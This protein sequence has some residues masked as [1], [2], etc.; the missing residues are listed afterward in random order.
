MGG[1]L[2]GPQLQG[3]TVLAGARFDAL[4]LDFSVAIV[5]R[6][7]T[8]FGSLGRA[9]LFVATA[10]ACGP[11]DPS[12][13]RPGRPV[14]INALATSLGRPFETTRRN[15]NALVDAGLI[16]RAPG[17]LSIPTT[18]TP[19]PVAAAFV[20]FSHDLM[21]RLVEDIRATNLP[22][23]AQ[24][25]TSTYDHRVGTGIALDLLL[26]C[27]ECQGERERNLTRLALLG[28]VEWA[29]KRFGAGLGSGRGDDAPVKASAVA[30][31]TGLPYATVSRNL[32]QLV[33]DGELQRR[34]DGLLIHPARRDD[35]LAVDARVPLA[36]R[37][38]QLL[39]RLA[40][41]GFPMQQPAL[42]YLDRR[43]VPAT[44]G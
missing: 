7:V 14:S 22:L 24:Q 4:L 1:D 17:G 34:P 31:I 32:D 42:A 35:P 8:A 36:N 5:P 25:T 38:R 6:A 23:P 26:A 41:T 33:R 37:A 9:L 16:A 44:M 29:N 28:T 3:A 10:R 40:Q 30:R 19:N 13:A 27:F 43:P 12:G 20:D 11:F 2:S 15:A 21:V 18:A 39:G